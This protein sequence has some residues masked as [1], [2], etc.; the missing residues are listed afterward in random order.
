MIILAIAIAS[1]NRAYAHVR[2]VLS[3]E[4]ISKISSSR[5]SPTTLPQGDML[6]LAMLAVFVGVVVVQ[7]L[8]LFL[9]ER[10]FV[11]TIENSIAPFD[12]YVPL[13]LRVMV[14]GFLVLSGASDALFSPQTRLAFPVPLSLVAVLQMLSGTLLVLGFLTKIG[15]N[16]WYSCSNV[17]CNARSSRS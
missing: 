16:T 1:S 8:G 17:V 3:D 13:M 2:Y 7:F 6:A 4:E 9:S 11:K 5:P 15:A 10:G 12:N 14:G